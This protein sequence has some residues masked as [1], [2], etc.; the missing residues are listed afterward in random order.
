ML[1]VELHVTQLKLNLV[2]NIINGNA[3]NYFF[4][5]FNLTGDQHN[6]N[7][8]SRTSSLQVPYVKSFGK[9]SFQYTGILA[10]NEFNCDIQGAISKS[11]FKYLVK[12]FLS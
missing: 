5:S 3:Q 11:S 12:K 6:I 2:H 4:E 1:P 7:T 8:R 10:W 9:T